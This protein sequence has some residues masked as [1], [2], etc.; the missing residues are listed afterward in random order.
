MDKELSVLSQAEESSV[1]KLYHEGSIPVQTVDQDGLK[2]NEIIDIVN[3]AVKERQ[4]LERTWKEIKRFYN[5]AHWSGTLPKNKSYTTTNLIRKHVQTAQM[6][7]MDTKP[8]FS[9]FTYQE[10]NF[11]EVKLINKKLRQ[12]Y[13]DD[14]MAYKYIVADAIRYNWG[15]LKFVLTDNTISVKRKNPF[16]IFRKG[17]YIIELIDKNTVEI[18]TKDYKYTWDKSG[19][20]NTISRYEN[21]LG[22]VPFEIYQPEIPESI[23]ETDEFEDACIYGQ[24]GCFDLMPVNKAVNKMKTERLTKIIKITD[25]VL[26]KQALSDLEKWEVQNAQPG[27]V[28]ETNDLNAI[29]PLITTE[30]QAVNYLNNQIADEKREFWELTGNSDQGFGF[31]TQNMSGS[32]ITQL[33]ESGHKWTRERIRIYGAF[34]QRVAN[35]YLHLVK[36]TNGKI[37]YRDQAILKRFEIDFNFDDFDVDVKISSSQHIAPEQVT[38]ILNQYGQ[39][40]PDYIKAE[41][42]MSSLNDVLPQ[43]T[44]KIM[45]FIEQQ[46]Q[47]AE[48]AQ[49]AALKKAQEQAA[50][51]NMTEIPQNTINIPQEEIINE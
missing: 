42:L 2:D 6:L 1:L 40:L 36:L 7:I 26:L 8:F 23:E 15:V 47:Q 4:K 16:N 21:K 34:L 29:K 37:I 38:A 27:E 24:S 50:A 30:M 48:L 20:K 49:L 17:N 25:P 28:L 33:L 11:D 14:Y 19:E 46:K 31:S 10:S 41:I 5:G 44:E 39:N 3:S 51:Q 35:K 18:W 43:S 22:I 32:A 9:F 12:L 13:N 45:D